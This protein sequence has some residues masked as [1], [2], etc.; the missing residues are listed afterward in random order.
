MTQVPDEEWA[1]IA[2]ATLL[3]RVKHAVRQEYARLAR[4]LR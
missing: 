3:E 4:E 2:L 1:R